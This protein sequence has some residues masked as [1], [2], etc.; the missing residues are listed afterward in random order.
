MYMYTY[1]FA[2][3]KR[4]QKFP[5]WCTTDANAVNLKGSSEALPFFLQLW[6]LSL[7]HAPSGSDLKGLR[8][9][10][11]THKANVMPTG[12]SVPEFHGP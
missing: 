10:S 5:L 9:S 8:K 7:S 11:L 12:S 1:T 3:M 6:G 4:T 2:D